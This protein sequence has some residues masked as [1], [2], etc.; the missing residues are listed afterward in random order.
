[1]PLCKLHGANAGSGIFHKRAKRKRVMKQN[2]L[3][4]F[5][6]RSCAHFDDDLQTARQGLAWCHSFANS[7]FFRSLVQLNDERF[8]FLF[9]DQRH[10]L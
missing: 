5:F 3:D 7:G 2:F 1:M 8:A 4:R 10:G 9:F 6:L